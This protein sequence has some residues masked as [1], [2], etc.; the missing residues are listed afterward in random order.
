[1]VAGL[2]QLAAGVGQALPV[3]YSGG[4][5]LLRSGE[6]VAETRA[7][8]LALSNL[9]VVVKARATGFFGVGG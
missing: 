9:A 1:M 5:N 8:F 3:D 7:R 4:G 2:L 6:A